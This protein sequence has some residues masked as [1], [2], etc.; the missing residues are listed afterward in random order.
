MAMGGKLW[1]GGDLSYYGTVLVP[2]RDFCPVQLTPSVTSLTSQR[3]KRSDIE[4]QALGDLR[5][6]Q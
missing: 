1:V 3:N 4:Y 2:Y 6:T 5:C